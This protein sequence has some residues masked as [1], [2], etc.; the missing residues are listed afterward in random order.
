MDPNVVEVHFRTADSDKDGAVSGPEAVA[1]FGKSGL[2][3]PVL[4]QV[5]WTRL[6]QFTALGDEPRLVLGL[7][8][9]LPL[10]SSVMGEL[11]LHCPSKHQ[12]V[13]H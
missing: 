7:H 12:L 4:R 8:V 9:C 5:G 3:T 1:F 2:P 13:S 11:T 6:L 10:P